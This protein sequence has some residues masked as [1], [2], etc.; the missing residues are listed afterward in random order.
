MEPLFGAALVTGRADA[1]AGAGE[2]DLPPILARIDD[3]R[4]GPLLY[5][6]L[7]G[8]GELVRCP[9]ALR[10][11]L[12]RSAHEA[13]AT[14]LIQ[15]KELAALVE[16]LSD[17]GVAPLLLKG[18]AFATAL[19]PDPAL[20]VREDT[21]ILVRRSDLSRTRDA[22]RSLGYRRAVENSGAMASQQEHHERVDVGAR[23]AC[24]VHLRPFNPRLF[25]DVIDIDELIASACD[26]PG[27]PGAKQPCPAHALLLAAMHRIAHHDGRNDLLWLMDIKLLCERIA[28]DDFVRVAELAVR[29]RVARITAVALQRAVDALDAVVPADVFA[30]L[31]RTRHAEP[32]ARFLAGN[33]L[34]SDVLFMDLQA[35][36][37]W[38]LRARLVAEH[39]F[40][41]RDY[42]ASKYGATT[43]TAMALAYL[44]RIVRGAPGWLRHDEPVAPSHSHREA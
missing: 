6:S 20:R 13:A 36:P 14:S 24:D 31:A 15:K 32:S 23:H 26:V 25:S 33:L 43:R 29:G 11:R 17:R 30:R 12:R 44:R 21:D 35:I 4:I 27:V 41:P 28:P 38:R 37:S 16:A 8:S 1:F 5:F 22:L 2:A 42:M 34:P 39:L 9:R 19:Y 40:P 3:E 18:A 10:E 7:S